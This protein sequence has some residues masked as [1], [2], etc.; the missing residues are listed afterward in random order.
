[1]R[2]AETPRL[3]TPAETA[4]LPK[5]SRATVY[6]LAKA[7]ALPAL[8]IGHGLRFDAAELTETIRGGAR[9]AGV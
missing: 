5:V 8:R 9:E 2:T 3:L 4:E 6:R 7:D 1:V